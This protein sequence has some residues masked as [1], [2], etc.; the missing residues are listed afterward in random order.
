MEPDLFA[1]LEASLREAVAI[2]RGEI[3]AARIVRLTRL[4]DGTI[5]RVEIDPEEYRREILRSRDA[6]SS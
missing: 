4:P 5:E 3:P 6:E 1:Q 2:E